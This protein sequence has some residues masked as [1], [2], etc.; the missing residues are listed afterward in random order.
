VAKLNARQRQVAR[1][2]R[3]W[4][5]QAEGR[6]TMKQVADGLGWSEATQS[7]MESAKSPMRPGDVMAIAG[8]LQVPLAE[9]D[10]WFKKSQDADKTSV[11]DQVSPDAI[12]A[13]FGE[14]LDFEFESERTDLLATVHVPALLQDDA[15]SR[16][17]ARKTV[18]AAELSEEAL[19]Q[20]IEVRGRR[21][22]RLND[23]TFKVRAVIFEPVLRGN[24]GGALTMRRQRA[25]LV[26]LSRLPN[27]D[28]RVLA[29]KKTVPPIGYGFSILD[30]GDDFPDVGW[31]D[32]LGEGV[33]IDDDAPKVK[34]HKIAFDRAW[35]D[36]EEPETSRELIMA[37]DNR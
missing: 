5:L 21:Q 8:Y 26:E 24:V 9:R 36:A 33:L 20:A 2:V 23:P 17:L 1:R 19:D 25:R 31:I 4:R 12:A 29:E 18:M 11:L 10:R 14:Y 35:A 13:D 32:M 28:L 7:R 16:A 22:T 6:P 27:V 34:L 15:Y 3:A 30:F 37:I